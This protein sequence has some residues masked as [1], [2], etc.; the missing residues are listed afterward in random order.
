MMKREEARLRRIFRPLL[1]LSMAAPAACSSADDNANDDAGTHTTADAQVDSTTAHGDDTGDDATVGTDAHVGAKD[2][3]V[4]GNIDGGSNPSIC[5][6]GPSVMDVI[7]DAPNEANDGAPCSFYESLPCGLPP[8]ITPVDCLLYIADC[9]KLLAQDAAFYNCHVVE[10]DDGGLF[11]DASSLSIE[12]ITCAGGVGRR[13]SG[14]DDATF[15][16]AASDVGAFFARVAHLEAA[17][18]HAFRALGAELAHHGAPR[19]LIDAAS[20]SASDER[21]HARI[22]AKLAR[23][24]GGRTVRPRVR[25]SAE[26]RTLE[27][28]AIE[29]AVEGCVRET[30]GAL[31]ASWQAAHARDA[32]IADAMTAIADDETRHAA[33]AWS[34]AKWLDAH[35][36]APARARVDAA[37]RDAIAALRSDAS[38]PLPASLVAVAGLPSA[39]DAARLVDRLERDL[40]A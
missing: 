22:T 7:D 16:A 12:Y 32:A 23:R 29:N 15:E 33:L 25:R 26:P 4:D 13:P 31:I 19:E 27:A 9:Q 39:T 11:A 6:A 5:D 17:S 40:W 30:Y 24:H 20:R 28:I 38:A 8:S 2:G 37:R 3:G 35:L 1:I 21:R 10:C 14:L 34:V 18:V 36:D